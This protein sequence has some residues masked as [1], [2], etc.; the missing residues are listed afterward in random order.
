MRK[1]QVG[2]NVQVRMQTSVWFGKKGVIVEVMPSYVRVRF[3]AGEGDI[4]HPGQLDCLDWK[5]I[6]D[7]W[8]L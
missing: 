4:F 6:D 3:K 7:E 8:V 5:P 1:P 2:D